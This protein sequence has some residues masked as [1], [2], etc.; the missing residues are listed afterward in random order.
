MAYTP[1]T[2]KDGDIIT[3]D[4]L[5]NIEAGIGEAMRSGGSGGVGIESLKQTTV[6]TESGGLNEW[7]AAL[8]DGTSSVL[9]VRNGQA[10]TDGM[11]PFIGP[12]G[13]WW[14][15]KQNTG[16]TAHGIPAGG[17][18]GQVLTKQS[19]DD[20][21]AVWQDAVSGGGASPILSVTVNPA[22]EGTTVTAANGTA[23]VSAVTNADGVAEIAVNGLGNW[24]VSAVKDGETFSKTV[25][26]SA[27]E[28]YSIG[29]NLFRVY[30]VT[31]DGSESTVLTRTDDA[32][33]F[34]D[35]VAAVG[36]GDGSSPFDTLYPWSEMEEYN[37]IDGA[38]AYKKGD[39]GFSRT[40]YDTVVYIP[41][42]WYQASKDE[43]TGVYTWKIASKETDG[44]ELHPGSGKYVGKYNSGAGY[45]SKS[46]LA[47]LVNIT[48]A[49]ART[50][51][52]NK[53]SGWYQYDYMTW[54]AVWMLYQVEF[55]NW[56]SQTVVGNG[57][58]NTSAALSTGGTDSMIYHTGRAAGT[59][60]QVQVKYRGIEDL[61]GNV[62]EWIDGANFN[63]RASCICTN[64][65]NYA[66]DTATN[67]TAA[68]VT[69]PS[70]GWTKDIG[71]S[72][73]FPWAYLPITN[74]GSA[75]TCIPD[76][77]HSN[78][79]WR[80]LMVGGH[81]GDATAAGLWCFYAYDTSLTSGAGIGAR[82]L[83]D[84]ALAS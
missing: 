27:V 19:D 48:R 43:N 1:R 53:G 44:F 56:D 23:S 59:D 47:P 26:V 8:T 32:A 6:S 30:G 22:A 40:D 61:W 57:N 75:T 2:W 79:G 62:W 58:T 17:K 21:D 77:V 25:S 10:G 38:V 70:S 60:G 82:L 16:I 36:D 76:Y 68:G 50:G 12:D 65:A 84:P 45:V 39:A 69:L 66:D 83:F 71:M 24:L 31:W 42:F 29:L 35:P 14:I 5:N 11:T 51:S 20:Y 46:G 37:I 34:V 73:A 74:G 81:C 52:R 63:D 64:P 67:Y 72:A 41:R 49:D 78:A 54:C 18:A 4:K 13:N 7:T 28:I 9:Q 55:A 15:G 80:V 3:A 33:L